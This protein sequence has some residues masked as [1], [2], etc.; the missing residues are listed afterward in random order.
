MSKKIILMW[1]AAAVIVISAVA[2]LAYAGSR[3]NVSR[4]TP[5]PSLK[6][7]IVSCD[8]ELSKI[9]PRAYP[10]QEILKISRPK[11]NLLVEAYVK[12]SCTGMEISGDY[13][14]RGDDFLI[15]KYKNKGG[16]IF[17]NCRCTNRMIFEIKDLPQKDY[18]V[19]LER[20]K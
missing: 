20:Q 14:I 2:Y 9:P 4:Q 8:K 12:A 16:N 5:K 1:V 13:E 3:V 17:S 10:P 7:S 15:V 11:N 6:F 19:I 18:K